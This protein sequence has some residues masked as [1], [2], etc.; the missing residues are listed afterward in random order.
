MTFRNLDINVDPEIDAKNEIE[1]LR[2]KYETDYAKSHDEAL[3]LVII[4]SL[5]NLTAVMS[6]SPI[7]ASFAANKFKQAVKLT[8]QFINQYQEVYSSEFGET[9][10]E[11]EKFFDAYRIFF[12]AS[13]LMNSIE[14]EQ[15]TNGTEYIRISKACKLWGDLVNKYW[16]IL[17]V[18]IRCQLGEFAHAVQNQTGFGVKK[19]AFGEL[20]Q[21]WQEFKEQLSLFWVSLENRDGDLFIKYKNAIIYFVESVAKAVEDDYELQLY[22]EAK[23]LADFSTIKSLLN[24]VETAPSWSGDDFEECLEYINDVR[25]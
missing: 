25:S 7:S 8:N 17:K 4:E 6:F 3:N 11:L 15:L 9:L 19:G 12:E 24:Y 13:A 2:Q 10:K 23:K 14:N 5:K 16:Y 21:S 1:K 20:K 18:N 22:K